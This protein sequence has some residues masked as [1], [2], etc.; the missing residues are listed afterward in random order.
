MQ[1][2]KP[3]VLRCV[4]LLVTFYLAG[5]DTWSNLTAEDQ[6]LIL[7]PPIGSDPEQAMLTLKG[8]FEDFRPSIFSSVEARLEAGEMQFLFHRGVPE[9]K[10]L[11]TLFLQRGV[12]TATL[13][14]G[15]LVY[16]DEDILSAQTVQ[17]DGKVYLKLVVSDEAA[18]RIGEITANNIGKV[19]NVVLDGFPVF[20]ST[21]E[22]AFSKEFKLSAPYPYREVQVIES[23][24]DHGSL[25]GVLGLVGASEGMFEQNSPAEQP[26]A[27]GS[28]TEATTAETPETKP[29]ATAAE[30]GH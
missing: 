5:C 11:T 29:A 28:G 20:N 10:F 17:M 7:R 8:R 23:L 12:L 22:G 26:V 9:S 3:M 30:P 1:I 25:S 24:L 19:T 27:E 6:M 14:T 18:R 4:V 21:I 2:L 13:E 16:N 15:E